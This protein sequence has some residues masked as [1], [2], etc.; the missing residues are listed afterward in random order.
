MKWEPEVL[1]SLGPLGFRVE[2]KKEKP[3]PFRR[4]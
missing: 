4:G 1:K 3:E 2:V